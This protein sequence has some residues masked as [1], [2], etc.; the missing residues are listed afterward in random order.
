MSLNEISSEVFVADEPIVT[1]SRSEIEFLKMRVQGM[2]RGR[3]RLCAHPQNDDRLHEM[4]IVLS[5]S[6][7][8]RPHKHLAKSE[9]LYVV[10]GKVDVVAL[11][12]EGIILEVIEMGEVTSGLCFYYRISQPVYH[13]MLIRSDLLVIHETTNGPFRKG[14][15]L[16]ASWSPEENDVCA[17][18]RFMDEL[19]AS[20]RRFLTR[21]SE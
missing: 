21:R 16:F 9:S 17:Y 8:I 3:V 5:G 11:D 18:R 19:S 4:F 15:A 7:Y 10:E 14:D 2:P 20:I 1:V 6:S 13:T 12:D